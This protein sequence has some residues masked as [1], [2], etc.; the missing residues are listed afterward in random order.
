MSSFKRANPKIYAKGNPQESPETE[1]WKQ[2]Y[3][4]E[5]VLIKELGSID[6]IDFSSIEPHHFAVSSSSKVQI[7]NP[8]TNKPLQ[9]SY[10]N[11]IKKA[12]GGNF[13]SDGLLLCAGCEESQIKIFKVATKAAPP[14]RV[15]KGHSAPVHRCFFSN[16]HTN[17]YIAS[18]SDDKTVAL[19]D[20][21]T[22]KQL[23]SYEEHK[24]YV[25]AGAISPVSSNILVSGG[26]DNYVKVYDSRQKCVSFSV[27]HGAPVES[28]VFLPSGGIFCTAGGTDVKVWDYSTG[29]K[30][31]AKLSNHHKTITCLTV[32]KD[33]KNLLSGGL[34][35]QVKIYDI[36]QFEVVHT[37]SYPN[38][39]LS[40]D[41][42]PNKETLAVGM[43]DG[44]LSINRKLDR[45][46]L[47]RE[48][49]KKVPAPEIKASKVADIKVLEKKPAPFLKYEEHLRKFDYSKALDVVLKPYVT[50]K[51]PQITVSAFQ[52][53]IRRDG[54]K[55][56]IVGRDENSL[57][58]LL[59]FIKKNLGN[60]SFTRIL[61][62]V[63]NT[64][65]AI[66]KDDRDSLSPKV[67]E[68]MDMIFTRFEEIDKFQKEHDGIIGLLELSLST[69]NLKN[70]EINNKAPSMNPSENAQKKEIVNLV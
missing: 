40:M 25:R 51:T 57:L 8:I 21:A 42:S 60:P 22:E 27:D 45:K 15:Y 18:F 43:V 58:I 36:S 49:I 3:Q 19:W 48:F 31:L 4:K 53:L 30:L 9:K 11:F 63:I 2:F 33:G 69:R 32:T 47:T 46:P 16:D 24:D 68:Q 7:Y 54:L 70:P 56:A 34:D 52:E 10:S 6:Y 17:P 20:I 28:V 29:G 13:R 39:I 61:L 23:I 65:L 35:R 14:L 62:E 50:K 5:A 26:Y 37:I 38:S 1:C 67:C 44:L 66:Y 59:Q 55:R 41:I 12:Y 64:I